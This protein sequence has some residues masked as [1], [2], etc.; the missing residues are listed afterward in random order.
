MAANERHP[1]NLLTI[2]ELKDKDF[3]LEF[4]LD[5]N[6]HRDILVI[7]Y[8]DIL[9]DG[10]SL[11]T[12]KH[13]RKANCTVNFLKSKEYTIYKLILIGF[14]ASEIRDNF[15]LDEIINAIEN[16]SNNISLLELKDLGFKLEELIKW[17]KPCDLKNTN[18][19]LQELKNAR[20]TTSY[21]RLCYKIVDFVN[22]GY[23][24]KDLLIFSYDDLLSNGFK[25]QEI[26]DAITIEYNNDKHSYDN[27]RSVQY[28][29][30]KGI[31]AAKLKE[32]GFNIIY[33]KEAGFSVDEL[34]SAGFTLAELKT[35]EFSASELRSAKFGVDELKSAGFGVKELK[36]AGFGVEELKSA[37]FGVEELKSAGYSVP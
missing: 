19:T 11:F 15:T 10:Y 16:I 27:I 14:P 13:F 32:K 7:P 24:I 22:A 25:A 33:F 2:Q 3:P 23:T 31:S 28:F 37:G 20:F 5:R 34:K 9:K 8:I 18:Y 17:H 26:L 12:L 35:G 30:M 1:S 21:L 6:Y 4:F 29:K 36:S